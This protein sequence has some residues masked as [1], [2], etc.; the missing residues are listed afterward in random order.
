MKSLPSKQ[1]KSVPEQAKTKPT[2]EKAKDCKGR[3]MKLDRLKLDSYDV[4]WLD[5]VNRRSK[6]YQSRKALCEKVGQFEKLVGVLKNLAVV[7]DRR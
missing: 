1:I 2:L 6:L 4:K 5:Q 7:E 3:Y